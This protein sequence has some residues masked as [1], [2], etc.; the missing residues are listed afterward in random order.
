LN[1]FVKV[2]K[3]RWYSLIDIGPTTCHSRYRNWRCSQSYDSCWR[4]SRIFSSELRR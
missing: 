1:K 2:T 4:C 3:T